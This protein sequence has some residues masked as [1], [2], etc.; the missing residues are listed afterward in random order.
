MSCDNDRALTRRSFVSMFVLGGVGTLIAGC[1]SS[2]VTDIESDQSGEDKSSP[3]REASQQVVDLLSD[4]S[5][6]R[7]NIIKAWT[8]IEPYRDDE[9]ARDG[10][11]AFDQY[12]G[13][14]TV[15]SIDDL[16]NDKDSKQTFLQGLGSLEAG[17]G[18]SAIGN[19]SWYYITLSDSSIAEGVELNTSSQ[20]PVMLWCAR[21]IKCPVEPGEVKSGHT[22]SANPLGS[23]F[24]SYD[25]LRLDLELEVDP[26][27]SNEDLAELL[28]QTGGLQDELVTVPFPEG[29]NGAPGLMKYGKCSLVTE[30]ADESI[31]SVD[32]AWQ[33][34]VHGSDASRSVSIT[35]LP[36]FSYDTEQA[37]TGMEAV[38]SY[39]DLV[40][41]TQTPY[42]TYQGLW[43][44]IS[45]P[46]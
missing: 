31:A 38:N 15:L 37:L 36:L 18:P 6:A 40:S 42:G 43:I 13:I 20:H 39:D 26:N 17:G 16:F 19:S 4:E 10:L 22:N 12:G 29:S 35:A 44:K 25:C 3:A 41:L 45:R 7:V 5:A 23:P 8:L 30:Y 32:G 2:N 27:L 14:P 11:N 1:S 9:D 33:V 34:R 21:S 46:S 28:C 24:G